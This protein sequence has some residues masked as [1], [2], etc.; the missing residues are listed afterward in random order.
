MLKDKY[1]HGLQTS[2][3]KYAKNSSTFNIKNILYLFDM[4]WVHWPNE[5]SALGPDTK[6]LKVIGNRL[7]AV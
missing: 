6:Y 5:L 7:S 4:S 1:Q 3:N 2:V